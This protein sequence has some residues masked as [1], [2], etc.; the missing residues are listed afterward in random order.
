MAVIALSGPSDVVVEEEV[1][2][3]PLV[4]ALLLAVPDVAR[5]RGRAVSEMV[6]LLSTVTRFHEVVRYVEPMFV[7]VGL[8]P[9]FPSGGVPLSE[10][11][12]LRT[13][14]MGVPMATAI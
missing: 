13:T 3:S 6:A 7:A 9:E 10:L 14:V 2:K 4:I 12:G 5:V 8:L 11:G 1:W